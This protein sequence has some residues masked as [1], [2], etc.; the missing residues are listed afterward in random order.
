MYPHYGKVQKFA[1][2]VFVTQFMMSEVSETSDVR[3]MLKVT[4]A[5]RKSCCC[6]TGGNVVNM[7]FNHHCN[8]CLVK[9]ITNS[10]HVPHVLTTLHQKIM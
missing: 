4:P 10:R 7:D 8:L 2:G 9:V 5:R 1:Y 6:E 3:L